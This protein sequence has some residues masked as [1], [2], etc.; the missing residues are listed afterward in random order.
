MSVASPPPPSQRVAQ[1][2]AAEQANASGV[3]G[4]HAGHGHPMGSLPA[5][6]VSAVGIVFGDI[7]TSPLYAFKECIHGP[8]GVHA[9]RENV[10]GVLSLIVWSLVLIVTGKY[11]TFVMRADNQGEGGIFALLALTPERMRGKGS[12][13]GAVALLVIAGASLLYG[14]GMIT[15]AISVLSAV[16][17]L[18]TEAKSLQDYVVPIT[19]VLL[20][21]L[22]LIQANGTERVGR[23]FGPV[24]MVWFL[25]LACLG[26]YHVSKNPEVLKAL[27][28]I[29]A[30]VFFEHNK[31]KS[32]G[33]L[34]SVVLAITGGEAL[35]AD[36]GHFGAKPIRM[37]WLFIVLPSLLLEYFGQGALVLADPEAAK[38]LFFAMVPSGAPTYA[39]VGLA[40]ISAII[41]SQALISGAF[42]L[43]NSAVQLGFFPRV[44]IRHTSGSAEGQIYVPEINWVL[45]AA[46]ITLVIVFQESSKL[47]AAYG[48]AVT[49]AMTITSIVFFVV[50]RN[51]WKWPLVAALPL[52]LFFW[53]FEL[54]FLFANAAKFFHGG[55]VPIAIGAV[56]FSIMVV[57]RRGRRLLAEALARKTKPVDEFLQEICLSDETDPK[58]KTLPIDHRLKGSAV[59]M[60][61]LSEGIPPTL[62]HHVERLRVLH[63]WLV[64]LTITTARVP[65]VPEGQRTKIAALGGG[66]HRVIGTYGFMETPDVPALLK[67]AV[68]NGLDAPI[69]DTVTYFLG[70]ETILALP[71]GRMG[72]VEESFFAVLSRN[73]RPAT[74][75]FKLP[76]G[77]VIEIGTQIDL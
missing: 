53:T 15:P 38:N 27:N 76:P 14:D 17:G 45:A 61:S 77:Q 1:V 56:F 16:E 43:T 7:G 62:V 30:F 9:T 6:V 34:G 4:A 2:A 32:V 36:M 67:E 39:L 23:L 74:A 12:S 57:W 42:S 35:Y 33:V 58:Q 70:R 64:I 37:A 13:I 71:G 19:C 24:M 21:G 65:Y 52:L 8:H 48:I 29:H 51:T 11:V 75:H 60:A 18:G 69:D 49:C 50:V 22:F 59:V 55:Y 26:G 46:S 5:L 10:L 41:A 44:T 25:T 72:E 28:P 54:P 73:S 47:A 20:L 40:T 68:A 31:M 66:I 3:G 63:E